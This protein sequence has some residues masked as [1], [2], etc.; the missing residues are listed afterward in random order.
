MYTTKLRAFSCKCSKGGGGG[1]SGSVGSRGRG[2]APLRI[3][4]VQ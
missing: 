4:N 1:R 2:R 3:S